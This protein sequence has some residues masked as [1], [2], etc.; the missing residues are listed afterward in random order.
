MRVTLW[1]DDAVLARPVTASAQRHERRARLY[2][3]LEHDDVVGYGEVSPQPEALNG[4]PSLDEVIHEL[5]YVSVPQLLDVLTRESA[6][7]GWARF[8][9]FAGSRSASHAAVALVEMALLDRELR[10]TNATASSIW[11]VH[12]A[13]PVQSTLSLLDPPG[14]WFVPPGVSRVRVKTAPGALGGE[15]LERLAGLGVGIVLDYNCSGANV[16]EVVS[17]A[18]RLSAVT[19]LDAVEQPFAPGNLIE[20]AQL[21]RALH[22]AV[23]IDEGVRSWGDIHQIVRYE[24]ATMICVKPARVGGLANARTFILRAREMGLRVYL[25]GFFES[26]YARAVHRALAEHC[27]SEP[28]DLGPVSVSGRAESDELDAL[29]GGFAVTPSSHVLARSRVIGRWS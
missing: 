2:L 8:N 14:S 20:H 25:G 21:A 13:T 3:A 23:S 7:P 26:P 10:A 11:P 15:A 22:V 18:E 6:A 12:Y 24:S 16:A 5:E 1:R 17:Q 27:V 9:R 19:A 28:S 4:D 29:E